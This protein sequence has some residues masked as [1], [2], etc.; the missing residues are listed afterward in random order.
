MGKNQPADGNGRYTAAAGW[1]FPQFRM[2]IRTTDISQGGETRRRWSQISKKEKDIFP[3]I[4]SR[5]AIVY[6]SA[7]FLSLFLWRHHSVISNKYQKKQLRR[8]HRMLHAGGMA[9]IV[10]FFFLFF[11]LTIC[12][13][14]LNRSG[15]SSSLTSIW[16]TSHTSCRRV[17]LFTRE[18]A[19]R[20]RICFKKIKKKDPETAWIYSCCWGNGE[21]EI[22]ARPRRVKF[23]E[24]YKRNEGSG[25]LIEHTK[26]QRKTGRTLNR[27]K[28]AHTHKRPCACDEVFPVDLCAVEAPFVPF[29]YVYTPLVSKAHHRDN[30]GWP[31]LRPTVVGNRFLMSCNYMPNK[32]ERIY[33]LKTLI[34]FFF[35]KFIFWKKT[36]C[37]SNAVG[38]RPKSGNN[39]SAV[40]AVG[41]NQKWKRRAEP[42]ECGE[43]VTVIG[44]P[45]IHT[46]VA[47]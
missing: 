33:S 25:F 23:Q 19:R 41:E 5:Y 47:S 34:S 42:Q 14:M 43:F 31:C 9:L 3:I 10:F 45:S 4:T 8:D 27:V 18:T 20:A 2:Y 29:S 24:I 7:L 35:S 32:Q 44:Q 12:N 40:G 26:T 28:K 22:R 13:K 17:C 39:Q 21:K 38:K 30:G 46:T 15:W 1:E 36:I 37:Q 16:I 6:K 11:L